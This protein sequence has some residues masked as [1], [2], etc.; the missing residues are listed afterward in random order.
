MARRAGG[1]SAAESLRDEIRDLGPPPEQ[2][3]SNTFSDPLRADEA[4]PSAPSRSAPVPPEGPPVT[5]TPEGAGE[6][7]FDARG[8]VT[9]LRDELRVRDQRDA[10]FQREMALRLAGAQTVP[11]QGTGGQPQIDPT[12]QEGLDILQVTEDDLA[13][14]FMGGPQAAQVVSRALQAVYL[15]AVNATEKRLINYYNQDQGTRTTQQYIASRAQQMQT[16]FWD[17]YPDLAQHQIVVQHYA[18]QVANEQAE[19]PRFDWESAQREVARRTML[20]LQ[21]QYNVS[22]APQG[23]VPGASPGSLPPAG[24]RPTLQSRLRPVVGEM[25]GG[26]SRQNGASQRSQLT[27]EILDLGRR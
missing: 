9:R 14:V 23:G 1:D 26:G 6:E 20:H 22:F 27:S 4:P 24:P 12:L 2:P 18:A 8:E 5:P 10:L 17:A 16:A 3:S 7:S 11:Q 19:S 13:Q 25:S 15:L 21:Q